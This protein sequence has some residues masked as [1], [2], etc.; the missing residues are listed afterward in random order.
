MDEYRLANKYLNKQNKNSGSKKYFISLINRS[1]ISFLLLIISMCFIK[2]NDKNKL[3]IK[4]NIYN[5][6]I[7]FA[8]INKL[9]ESYFGK[10]YPI[11][12]L[13]KKT[14]VTIEPVFS[15]KLA[16][17]NK[18][19]YKEGV[20]L[21]VEDNYLVPILES[22]IV[23][24]IGEK[25]NYGYTIIVEQVNGVDIWYV[26]LKKTDLKLYDYVE[27]GKLLGE[28]DNNELYLF[29]QKDGKFISYKEYI[30]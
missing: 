1:L 14:S 11:E 12:E 7:N 25:D 21:T 3:F 16:Y 28:I 4:E 13:E 10:I 23:V 20:K 17:S 26:G 6:N 29:Y 15:E 27:K 24:Y 2:S 18:E 30:K 9:Y 5:K 22:G 8:K 19:D